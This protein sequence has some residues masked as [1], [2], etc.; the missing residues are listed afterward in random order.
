VRPTVKFWEIDGSWSSTGRLLVVDRQVLDEFWGGAG[1]AHTQAA[2]TPNQD[3][4]SGAQR[5]CV[6][7]IGM[8]YAGGTGEEADF[9]RSITSPKRLTA[10]HHPIQGRTRWE[11][12][13]AVS[14]SVGD[15]LTRSSLSSSPPHRLRPSR[16]LA[17]S[18]SGPGVRSRRTVD[19][20][21]AGVDGQVQR[22]CTQ[23]GAELGRTRA[24]DAVHGG[25][26]SEAVARG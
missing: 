5:I 6:S 9:I 8:R 11:T 26:L 3:G 20:D 13:R 19:R 15:D 17:W 18:A 22:W 1:N 4:L 7:V 24:G 16:M 21:R 10:S 25:L 12:A 14:G 2:S 23:A